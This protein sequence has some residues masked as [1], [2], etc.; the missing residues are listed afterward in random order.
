VVAGFV[1]EDADDEEVREAV[2]DRFGHGGR[3]AV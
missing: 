3:V 1:G 2:G